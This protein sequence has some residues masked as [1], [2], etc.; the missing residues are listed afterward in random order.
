MG[1]ENGAWKNFRQ[2]WVRN[3]YEDANLAQDFNYDEALCEHGNGD[4]E[5]PDT[6]NYRWMLHDD[7]SD[8]SNLSWIEEDP[9]ERFRF[10]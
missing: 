7:D 5:E 9:K 2:E 8:M 3:L 4:G 1:Y 10:K 6:R